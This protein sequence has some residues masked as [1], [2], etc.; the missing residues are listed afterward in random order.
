MAK[1]LTK[2]TLHFYWRHV[3]QHKKLFIPLVI[4]MPAAL[5]FN[6]YASAWIISQ[7][8]NKL[9]TSHIAANVL[10][11]TFTPW[12]IAYIGSVILG[13]LVLWR[14]TLYLLW[15]LETHVVYALN[16]TSFDTL[17]S[18]SLEF[19]NNRFSGSV[20]SQV[21]KFSSAYTQLM[22]TFIFNVVPL[23]ASFIFV[24]VILGPQLPVF[25]L[26]IAALAMAFMI[27]ATF[28]FKS[29]RHL[30]IQETESQVKLSGHLADSI[31]NI[32]AIKSHSSEYLE[33][34]RY[35]HLNTDAK[36]ASL[37]VMRAIIKRD[38]GFGTVIT[39]IS[40]LAF[41]MLIGGKGWF[42][43]EIGTLVLAMTYSTQ[44]LSQLWN[45]NN[46]LRGTNR[47]FG[48][49][50][51]MTKVFG[52]V[53]SV[54]DAPEA[55]ALRVKKGAIDFDDIVYRHADAPKDD[56]L[57][58]A[59]SLAIKP[60]EQIGLVG[61]SGSGKTTL[62]KLLLRFA[63]I[64]SGQILIDGQNIAGITQASLRAHIAYV[65][66]EP[67]LF[68]RS[69]RENIAYGNPD[70]TERQIRRAARQANALDF[71]KKLPEGLDTT[72]GERGVKLSGGQRQRIAIARAILKDAPILV[73]DEATSALDSE[74]ESLIQ[75]ALTRLMKGRTAIVIA[76]RLSTI[77]KLD[78]I[79]VLE[80]GAIKEQGSHAE[81]VK[82]RGDYAKLWSHQS[83]G[84]IDE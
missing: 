10:W 45:F 83:G 44:I 27:I 29:I 33:K 23:V 16:R 3:R 5:F 12:I 69:L 17:A 7:V 15:K 63:D 49:A 40:S 71:I 50:Q 32:M 79:V 25:T 54:V 47:A 26:G 81:L 60:G 9:T 1:D 65:P 76:H 22:D 57:F 39:A 28:S 21:N 62:T 61:Q 43:V 38:V 36:H 11:P 78:R 75:D 64:N 35:D 77:A 59:L 82:K 51:E 58:N 37:R 72:V 74:S 80:N 8:I 68:H 6:N 24:F 18:Q 34:E 19:H 14:M 70:A 13:E 20:V 56:A 30:N 84:F 55:V 41:I 48:D 42:H 2:Q 73:L 53:K 67:M 4:V 52:T 31:T 46:I 66:Q